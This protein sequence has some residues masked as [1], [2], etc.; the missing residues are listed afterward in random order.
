MENK[1]NV[2]HKFSLEKVEKGDW[3]LGCDKCWW[4]QEPNVAM[5]PECPNCHSELSLFFVRATDVDNSS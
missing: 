3:F 1:T 2:Q 5:H 4:R